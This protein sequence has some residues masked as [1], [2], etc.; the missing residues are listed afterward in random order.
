MSVPGNSPP[1]S[2]KEIQVPTTGALD[3]AVDDAQAVAGEQ[4]VGQRVAGEA[5]GHGEDEEDETDHPVQLTRL[6]ERTGEEDAQHV[7]ADGRHEQQGRPVVH[8]THQEAAADVERDVER[9]RHGADI[10]MPLSGT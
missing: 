8:L 9:R 6:A 1:N 4:V 3:H 5:L 7:Q 2:R 10:S